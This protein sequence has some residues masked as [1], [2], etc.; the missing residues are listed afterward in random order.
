MKFLSKISVILVTLCIILSSLVFSVSAD[1]HETT[2]HYNDKVK[3][4]DSVQIKVKVTLKEYFGIVKFDL[5]FDNT[6]LKYTGTEG[7]V[8]DGKITF[9]A[10]PEKKVLTDSYYFEF[11]AIGEGKSK[12]QVNNS[13]YSITQELDENAKDFV[14]A[15]DSLRAVDDSSSN[16]AKLKSLKVEGYSLSP[17]FSPSKTSYTLEV[18]NDV[19]KLNITATTEDDNAKSTIFGASNLT[20]GEN[21]VKVTVTASD[22]TTKEYIIKVKR[23]ESED[24]IPEV[25]T[26]AET[27]SGDLL[28]V[29]VGDTEYIMSTILPEDVL[30]EGFSF[31]K[32]DVDGYDVD[33][34]VDKDKNFRIF[35]L[36]PIGSEEYVPF[37][38]NDD[39]ERFDK[40][41]CL[42]I[43]DNQYIFADLPDDI[44]NTKNTYL[45]NVTINGFSIECLKDNNN[46][47]SDFCYVYA[48]SNGEYSIYRYDIV[49]ETMQRYP[50]S[51]LK[52]T[53]EAK[54]G[55]ISRFSS[56]STNGK[57]IMISFLI[58]I[59]GVFALLVLLVVYLI[60]RSMHPADIILEDDDDDF[61][62][63][64]VNSQD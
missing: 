64:E 52:G 36:K 5:N 46:A 33:V 43:G 12:I 4:G 41:R 31:E 62:V 13:Q 6:I 56:L 32:N 19:K 11:E 28:K 14:G 23:L 59:L 39:I 35:Y 15:T 53:N 63:I 3:V 37:V 57:I 54:A 30:F 47:L 26:D 2:L 38:Y 55:L 7:I 17:S 16:N 22:G 27:E 34:A 21:N 44:K 50:E 58:V 51:L 9:T 40:L 25:S 18:P 45:S 20:I 60:K 48:F 29:S 24:D 8:S 1:T 61:D 42:T 10:V 49:E